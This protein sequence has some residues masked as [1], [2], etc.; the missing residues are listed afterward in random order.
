MMT[1]HYS[2]GQCIIS[3]V[4]A[5]AAIFT[6]LHCVAI[7]FGANDSSSKYRYRFMHHLLGDMLSGSDHHLP[8]YGT[9]YASA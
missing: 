3:R 9:A 1:R 8:Y 5:T 7:N 6:R 2:L 4:S